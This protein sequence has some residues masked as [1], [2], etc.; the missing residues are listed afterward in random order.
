MS[1][2][3]AI[4]AA[5]AEN[6]VIGR[7]EGL[8][9]RISSDL[10]RFRAI[11]MG[12][13]LL[14]GRRTFVSLPRPLPGRII[15]VVTRDAGFR[16]P[17]GVRAAASLDAA[18]AEAERAGDEL[19][20][21]EIAVVGGAELYAQTLPRAARL[22]LTR[23]HGRPQGDVLFPAFDPAAWH[24]VARQGPVQGEKDEF[25]VSYIDYARI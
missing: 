2:P 12:K 4:V 14:M 24:E 18:I 25:A 3:L 22:R 7:G 20:A 17:E 5:I 6:D 16:P 15:V 11:T 13:P 1:R 9:W 21:D 19:G 8:P 23:V 10:R